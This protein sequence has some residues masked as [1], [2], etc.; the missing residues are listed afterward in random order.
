MTVSVAL[1]DVVDLVA[2]VEIVKVD[3]EDVRWETQRKV[4]LQANSPPHSAAVLA[5]AVVLPPLK[6]TLRSGGRTFEIEFP[7]RPNSSV[8]GRVR[9]N[10]G[11]ALVEGGR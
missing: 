11:V 10:A 3:T 1:V 7:E 2:I 5:E 8:F 9:E 6:G 4:V